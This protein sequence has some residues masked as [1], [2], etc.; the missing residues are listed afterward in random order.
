[1]VINFLKAL[2]FWGLKVGN[3]LQYFI[4]FSTR[5]VHSLLTSHHFFLK[6]SNKQ[7]S[8]IL[9]YKDIELNPNEFT[10]IC[11]SKTIILTKHEFE[12]LKALIKNPNQALTKSMLFDIVWGDES[13]A[14]ENTLNVHISKIRNKLKEAN[15]EEDYIETIWGIGY[16]MKK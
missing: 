13:F 6:N 15:Q 9:K 10:V 1:M 3:T 8:S 11:N 12:L 14:D 7:T 5:N 4:T 16:R 2:V